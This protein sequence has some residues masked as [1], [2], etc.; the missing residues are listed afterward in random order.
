MLDQDDL[1]VAAFQMRGDRHRG[2]L[3]NALR[4]SSSRST[5]PRVFLE[6]NVLAGLARLWEIASI[7]VVSS[8]YAAEK[9]ERNLAKRP[10]GVARLKAV[11]DRLE[12]AGALC[13]GRT[14][15]GA[16][17]NRAC[18]DDFETSRSSDVSFKRP[19]SFAIVRPSSST[20]SAQNSPTPQSHGKV[21]AT[22]SA[23]GAI[24][25]ARL[26]VYGEDLTGRACA[27]EGRADARCYLEGARCSTR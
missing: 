23:S 7:A 15:R 10:D 5:T 6:A 14:I 12:I 20:Y 24:E 8:P 11:L 16:S 4:H 25:S 26:G 3:R 27:S 13:H 1:R 9:G 18:P 19:K 17:G 22:R 21:T 2:R